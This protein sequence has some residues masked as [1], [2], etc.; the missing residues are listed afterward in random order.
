MENECLA[1]NKP[2]SVFKDIKELQERGYDSAS[3]E[4]ATE[5]NARWNFILE[6]PISKFLA[7]G[8]SQVLWE[9]PEFPLID[10]NTI[11]RCVQGESCPDNVLFKFGFLPIW[12]SIGGN[13][14]AYH[15][16]TSAFYWA[17]HECVSGSEYISLPKTYEELPLN[18]ENLMKTIVK[19][20]EQDCASFL[21]DLRDGK[22]DAEIKKLD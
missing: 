1:S 4:E 10:I 22:H 6:S 21:L 11:A 3:I 5:W 12:T 14:I 20:S 8:D 13:L 7:E 18:F 15:P 19:F 9:N 2:M 17:D 16:E